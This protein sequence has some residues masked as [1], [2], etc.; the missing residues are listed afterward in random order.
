[1]SAQ[2]DIATATD[3][4]TFRRETRAWLEANC[5]AEMRQPVTDETDVC[6]GGRNWQFKNEAQKVWLVRMAER[7][8]TVPE[9]PKAYGGRGAT[10]MEQTI[11]RQELVRARMPEVARVLG[12]SEKFLPGSFVPS[13]VEARCTDSKVRRVKHEIQRMLGIRGGYVE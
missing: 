11:Y 9:W 10:A 7:G 8:W 5:P 3:L 2:S 4:E 12:N 6:W 13:E 1:M